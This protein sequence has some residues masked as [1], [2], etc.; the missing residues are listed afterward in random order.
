MSYYNVQTTLINGLPV[1]AG[2]SIS[3]VNDTTNADQTVLFHNPS[4][5]TPS[6]NSNANLKFNPS[7]GVV[8]TNTISGTN[9]LT[10]NNTS[11]AGNSIIMNNISGMTISTGGTGAAGNIVILTSNGNSVGLFSGVLN[12]G[13]TTQTTQY[14]LPT[15]APAS[16]GYVLQSTSGG[17]GAT[18]SWQQL[19]APVSVFR[20]TVSN[21]QYIDSQNSTNISGTF[22]FTL[23]IT[24]NHCILSFPAITTTTN[25][26]NNSSYMNIGP[27]PIP[28]QY[29]PF[30]C[31]N[32]GSDFYTPILIRST[33]SNQ[34]QG[35]AVLHINQAS[36]LMDI[37]GFT[38]VSG[39]TQSTGLNFTGQTIFIPAQSFAWDF[40]PSTFSTTEEEE[41]EDSDIVMV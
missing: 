10:L 4:G 41:T 17:A 34:T 1:G 9:G 27:Y 11:G 23:A 3:V 26:M 38:G 21:V 13:D 19:P 6:V 15:S 8:K 35:Q 28:S 7:T 2:S 30:V 31:T 33:S 25:L 39:N 24:G 40:V 20:V 14:S 37:E 16:S 32:T 12:I 18:V 29:R 22:D 5:S 36:G